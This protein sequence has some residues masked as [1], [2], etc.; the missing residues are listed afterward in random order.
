MEI[1]AVGFEDRVYLIGGGKQHRQGLQCD[2]RDL[3]AVAYR[4]DMRILAVAGRSGDLYLFDLESSQLLGKYPLHAGRIHDLAFQHDSNLI[5][6][7]GE[8]GKL[9]VFDSQSR[10]LVQRIGVTTG[11]LFAVTV[12]DGELAAVAGSDNLIRIVNVDQGDTVRNLKG[13]NGS[14]ATLASAGG[15]LFS[16]SYD[17]TLRRWAVS[18]ISGSNQRIA[19]GDARIDR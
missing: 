5:L 3:R 19:E 11:K 18:E 14:I 17:A 10:E 7:V 9:T 16:G 6:S 12:L 4:A 8:D 15:W 2:C 13:H 1:A